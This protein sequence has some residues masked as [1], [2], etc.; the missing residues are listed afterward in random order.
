VQKRLRDIQPEAVYVY[1]RSHALNL[2]LQ[3]A[4]CSGRCIR[5]ILSLCNEVA[6][7]FRESAKRTGI[8]ESVIFQIYLQITPTS[9]ASD[10]S[11][12][13]GRPC[14]SIRPKCYVNAL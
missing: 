2:A 8:L 3:E 1:C 14:K 7:F 5:D 10:Q 6:N 13:M 12:Y 11:Y 4:S 9:A